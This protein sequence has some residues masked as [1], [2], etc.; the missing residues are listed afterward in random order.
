MRTRECDS[1]DSATPV[2]AEAFALSCDLTQRG[3]VVIYRR[4]GT[5]CRSPCPMGAKLC[6]VDVSTYITKLTVTFRDVVNMPK[7]E[8]LQ[9]N[10]DTTAFSFVFFPE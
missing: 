8:L 6:H 2:G 10:L 3:L 5:N 9:Q 4:F 1:T 7:K